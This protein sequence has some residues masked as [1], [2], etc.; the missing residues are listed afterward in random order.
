[1]DYLLVRVECRSERDDWRFPELDALLRAA[2]EAFVR[3]HHDTYR[4][5][6][7]EA[8]ARAWNSA[9]LTVSDRRRVALLV[10][11]ELDHLGELGIVPE[12]DRGLHDLMPDRLV[13]RDDPR[14]HDLTLAQLVGEQ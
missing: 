5:L 13:D 3:G 9:D 2:G 12:P 8:V 4:D 14:L 10:A 7:T 11:E 6:R 1:M